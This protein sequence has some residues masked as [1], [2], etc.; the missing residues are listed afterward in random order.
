MVVDLSSPLDRCTTAAAAPEPVISA[1]AAAAAATRRLLQRWGQRCSRRCSGRPM[2]FSFAGSSTIA[3]PHGRISS[4]FRLPSRLC[5]PNGRFNCR[6]QWCV[7]FH[8][9]GCNHGDGRSSV[10]VLRNSNALVNSIRLLWILMIKSLYDQC[11]YTVFFAYSLLF[12]CN[13]IF[14]WVDPTVQ[15]IQKLSLTDSRV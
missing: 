8:F 3:P 10:C 1:V 6:K 9:V 5:R 2:V 12:Y 11:K 4:A 15:F 7:T 13:L 14:E